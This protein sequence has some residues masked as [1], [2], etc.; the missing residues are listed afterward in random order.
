MHVDVRSIQLIIMEN[1]KQLNLFVQRYRVPIMESVCSM[2]QIN[3]LKP[4][5]F[6]HLVILDSIVKSELSILVHHNRVE[7]M[8]H[9]FVHS[10]DRINVYVKMDRLDCPVDQIL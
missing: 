6:V 9:V 3:T 5:V 10:M 8:V 4:F 2:C 7:R 1:V